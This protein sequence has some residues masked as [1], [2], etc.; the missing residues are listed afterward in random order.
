PEI[1]SSRGD[2]VEQTLTTV[3]SLMGP[4]TA[5]ATTLPMLARAEAA[6]AGLRAGGA[7]H[8]GGPHHRDE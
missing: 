4:L 5:F 6:V 3:L 2:T 7:R 8:P 1:W